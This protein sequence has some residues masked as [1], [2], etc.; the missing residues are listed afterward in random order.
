MERR[1][2]GAYPGLRVAQL[3]TLA[4]AVLAAVA[5]IAGYWIAVPVFVAFWIVTA[6]VLGRRIRTADKQAR[7]E[8]VSLDRSKWETRE[9]KRFGLFFVGALLFLAAFLLI[10]TIITA[11]T[12]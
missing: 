8:G 12:S 10:A 11:A 4:L 9:F 7:A 1:E 2:A 6:L 3:V 5:V